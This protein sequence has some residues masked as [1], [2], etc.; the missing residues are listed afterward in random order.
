MTFPYTLLQSSYW[1]SFCV[2]ICFATIY[3]Q[4]IGFSNTK[5]GIVCALGNLAGVFLGPYLAGMM[6]KDERCAPVKIMPCILILQALCCIVLRFV[7]NSEILS[8]IFYIL[9]MMLCVAFDTPLLKVY[10]DLSYAE[11]K[12]DYS[13]AR[14]MGSLSFMAISALLGLLIEKTSV[15]AVLYSGILMTVYQYLAYLYIKGRMP[16][17]KIHKETNQSSSLSAFI[18]SQPAFA[19]MLC[20]TALLFFAHNNITGFL[21]N[22][23]KNVG[24]DTAVA[25]FLNSFM[26]LIEIPVMLF[27][28]KW[29][30]KKDQK[31]VLA[32]SF[33]AFSVKELSFALSRNLGG[34]YFS[35]LFQAPS[36]A[37]Y[38]ASI[39]PYVEEKIE[40]K[41]RAKAQSLAYTLTT[42]GSVL[43]SVFAGTLYDHTSVNNTLWISF[44]VSLLGT[45]VCL[46]AMKKEK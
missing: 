42:I 12:V 45:L 46:Y 19:I 37:L 23:V 14:G 25:G 40:Y 7:M 2:C 3:L 28:T 18:R 16:E 6:D 30:G 4:G 41:D 22:V 13:L 20:G 1:M 44:F 29:F 26:A 35:Y 27:Y 36:F 38:S 8:S 10:S 39:V 15:K 9:Y 43:S 24:G 5:L 32:A 17:I 33:I 21:I 34:L 11:K 31:K